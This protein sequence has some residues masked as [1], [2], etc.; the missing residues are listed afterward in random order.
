MEAEARYAWVGAAVLVLVGLLAGAL[1]WLQD[2]R[3]RE[4]TTVY[5]IHFEHQAL[6][7]LEVGAPVNLRGIKVGRVDEYSLSDGA[8]N[9]V[10]V[11]IRVDRRTP[12]RANTDAVITRNIVT[13][14][15]AITLRTPDPPG[16]PLT[17]RAP[18]E[19][20]PVI[21]EG[22]SNLE[23]LAGRAQRIGEQ[24]AQA[25]AQLNL[26]LN[27]E[28]R[29][30]LIDTIHEL[31]TL[32]AG[33]NQ[34]LGR[35]DRALERGSAAATAV[36]EAATRIAAAAGGLASSGERVA[37][38]TQAL[39]EQLGAA[40]ERTAQTVE[41][42]GTRAD[43]ALAEAGQLLAEARGT[44]GRLAASVEAVERQARRTGERMESAAAQIDDQLAAAV[45]EMR[46]T[47][48]AASRVL[49]RLRDPRAA[50]LGPPPR[51]LGPGEAG[52]P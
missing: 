47:T 43:H 4:Q 5:V 17:E 27:A 6:D 30:A 38:S 33:I 12:V 39:G 45:S 42:V 23:E 9:R 51:T 32:S 19:R 16:P 28:N 22:R 15:A 18:G 50:L 24:A 8:V 37:A 25:L 31:R 40:G 3:G 11:L 1:V 36:G 13:G 29:K 34:R 2:L 46:L 14:I 35:V 21:A 44:L 7:G 48:E 20:H 41:R 26:L 10:R 49:D 52:A